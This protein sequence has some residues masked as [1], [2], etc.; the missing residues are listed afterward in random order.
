M[1]V[2][3]QAQHP[4]LV[5][6]D[7]P[8]LNKNFITHTDLLRLQ[9]L[10]CITAIKVLL[11]YYTLLHKYFFILVKFTLVYKKIISVIFDKFSN[12]LYMYFAC[13]GVIIQEDKENN[14]LSLTQPDATALQYTVKLSNFSPII[15]GQFVCFKRKVLSKNIKIIFI[16]F[17]QFLKINLIIILL[18]QYSVCDRN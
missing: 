17:G 2:V 4:L 13:C 16:L 3:D 6:I 8:S 12:Y 15:I 18:L 9:V 10:S 5:R 1:Y 14:C 7:P 11:H